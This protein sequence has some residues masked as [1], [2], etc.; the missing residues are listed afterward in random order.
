MAEMSTQD[1]GGILAD[2]LMR[3]RAR[4]FV[5]FLDDDVGREGLGDFGNAHVRRGR[6]TTTEMR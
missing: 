3:D 6:T 4:Q 5:E 1:A 2:D